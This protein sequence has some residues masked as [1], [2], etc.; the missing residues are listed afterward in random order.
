MLASST[1]D[2]KRSEDVRARIA[3][4][5]GIPELW[6]AAVLRWAARNERFK[7]DGLPDRNT[8][9]LLY[10][11]LVGAWPIT[12]ER[13][14]A[15]ML[16]AVREAKRQT[17]WN[18]PNAGFEKALESF[19]AAILNDCEFLADIHTFIEPLILPG[20]IASLA[21]T[22]IKLTAPG[23][24]DT[25][26]GTELWDLSLVDP[27]NR[28]PVDFDLR[29][30]LIASL[31]SMSVEEVTG[32]MDEGLPKLWVIAKALRLRNKLGLYTALRITGEASDNAIA[33]S[34]GE[35]ITVVPRLLIGTVAWADT[36]MELPGEKKWRNVLTGDEFPHGRLLLSSLF[37]RFPV[38]LLTTSQEAG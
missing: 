8:E 33:Y 13:L 3:L 36:A 29:A 7:T 16:K 24:P 17:S 23:V 14:Q 25:Y 19:V 20:R 30:R 37:R 5:S 9:Y 38:A 22:L 35:I 10:Q 18:T 12:A 21:Q 28:R 4:L 15:Y 6:S 31:Q 26:Q 34:R 32:H 2:T 11:T 27:D 1:H